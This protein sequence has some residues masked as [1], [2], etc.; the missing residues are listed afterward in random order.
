MAS[1]GYNYILVLIKAIHQSSSNF[2]LG[3]YS[4]YITAKYVVIDTV[5]DKC[6]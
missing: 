4:Y 5:E 1:L 2:W 3:S 6:Q